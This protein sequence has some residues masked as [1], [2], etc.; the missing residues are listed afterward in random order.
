MAII[1]STVI[2]TRDMSYDKNRKWLVIEDSTLGQ[3][4]TLVYDDAC[5]VGF[6]VESHRT[7]KREVFA[8]W[9]DK[10]EN[11]DLLVSIYKPISWQLRDAGI[12]LHVLND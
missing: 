4:P 2:T 11:G 12:E 9:A 6:V 1:C 10:R 3:A 8:H 7:G 5:D